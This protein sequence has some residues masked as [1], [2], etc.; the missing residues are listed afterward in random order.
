MFAFRD[1]RPL[2]FD[3]SW[4]ILTPPCFNYVHALFWN[5]PRWNLV[6]S[7]ILEKK[8]KK[9]YIS[10]SGQPNGLNGE[11]NNSEN[12]LTS[13]NRGW[14]YNS[15]NSETAISWEIGKLHWK[16]FTT[17]IS[18]SV[19]DQELSLDHFQAVLIWCS[20]SLYLLSVCILDP[21]LNCRVSHINQVVSC[22]NCLLQNGT[23]PRYF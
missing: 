6:F 2:G 3:L 17:G 1:F 4:R 18:Y 20:V 23:L 16:R 7:H 22:K 14:F 12:L 11:V 8:I 9:T 10:G 15:F 13:T 21:F 5:R 19:S